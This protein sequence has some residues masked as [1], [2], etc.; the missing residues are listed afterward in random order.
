MTIS[1]WLDLQAEKHGDIS[2][3][4]LPTELTYDEEPDEMVF[5]AEI[6]P[7]GILCTKNHP[8][9]SVVRYGHWYYCNGQDKSARLHSD[10][11]M[12]HLLTKNRQLALKTARDHIQ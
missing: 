7:C 1:N 9:S 10:E 6:N 4:E 11:K 12:W 5:F 3:I 2:Q 8:F